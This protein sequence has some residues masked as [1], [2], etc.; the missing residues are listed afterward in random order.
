MFGTFD[1]SVSG[2]TAQRVRLDT[3][4]M[5]L[6]NINTTRN[7]AGEPEPFR[8]LVTIFAEGAGGPGSPGVRVQ[9]VVRD[10][11]PL[12]RVYEPQHPDAGP[13]GYVNYP[14]VDMVAENVDAIE[15]SRA[16]EAN[17]A[18]F[19]LAKSMLATSLRL[20]A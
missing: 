11:G 8:R 17:V 13:D 1:I 20:L 2:M 14:N 16:F 3:I 15:A 19:E 9:A 12:R 5:N 10:P 6:A 7:A 18:A 4:S